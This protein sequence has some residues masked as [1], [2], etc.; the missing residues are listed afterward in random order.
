MVYTRDARG[1]ANL[2]VNNELVVSDTVGGDF[3]NWNDY[4][5]LGIANEL[6]GDRPWLGELDGVAIYDQALDGSEVA[7]NFLA[8]K[9]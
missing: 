4:Y 1:V 6:T 7:Q 3:S 2:Y 5:C 8:G 9:F